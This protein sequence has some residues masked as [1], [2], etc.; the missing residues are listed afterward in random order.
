MTTHTLEI[1]TFN[2]EITPQFLTAREAAM[3]A[4]AREFEGFVS[5]RL[6]K[7]ADG[8]LA[9]ELVW[10]SRAD[11]EAAVQRAP[12]IPDAAAYLGQINEFVSMEYAEIITS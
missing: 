11:A 12:S 7:R 3:S 8:S 1:A 5:S 4:L 6:I 10:T 9:D 2:A